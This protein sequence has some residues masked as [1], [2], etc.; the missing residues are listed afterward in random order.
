LLAVAPANAPRQTFL[1][2]RTDNYEE[3]T[4]SKESY[5]FY[6]T[7]QELEKLFKVSRA[8]IYRWVKSGHLPKPIQLGAN[9]VRWK[10]SDIEAWMEEREAA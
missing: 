1:V 7:R 9:M 3:N 10:A 4:M 6:K 2:L 5:D 8:T